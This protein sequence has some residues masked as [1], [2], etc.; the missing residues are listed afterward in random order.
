MSLVDSSPVDRVAF[1]R[2]E[3][4]TVG[5]LNHK[6]HGANCLRLPSEAAQVLY[7]LQGTRTEK[8]KRL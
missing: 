3:D 6:D 7:M 1:G 4:V 2:L 5:T 8:W